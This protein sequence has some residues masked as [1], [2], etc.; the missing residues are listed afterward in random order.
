MYSIEGE[1]RGPYPT[2]KAQN[3]SCKS[4]H[5]QYKFHYDHANIITSVSVNG[6]V[7]PRHDPDHEAEAYFEAQRRFK[8]YLERK[9]EPACPDGCRLYTATEWVPVPGLKQQLKV[10][11]IFFRVVC[12]NEN[13]EA[14]DCLYSFEVVFYYTMLQRTVTCIPDLSGP[15]D[16]FM[17]P[18]SF[19]G[20]CERE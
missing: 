10:K 13:G 15:N 6:D 9:S 7:C 8:A 3:M 19:E 14:M 18:V 1:C 2:E 16:F 12:P 17:E 4:P 5:T 11:R 20:K